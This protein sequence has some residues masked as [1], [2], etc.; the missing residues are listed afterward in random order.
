MSQTRQ[1]SQTLATQLNRPVPANSDRP[2]SSVDK[3]R[4]HS[5]QFTAPAEEDDVVPAVNDNGYASVNL[6]ISDQYPNTN[7]R[8][9]NTRKGRSG[10]PA[11]TPPPS[12]PIKRRPKKQDAS[13]SVPPLGRFI[14][15]PEQGLKPLNALPGE[16]FQRFST[17]LDNLFT[18]KKYVDRACKKLS[19]DNQTEVIESGQCIA[20]HIIWKTKTEPTTK[21]DLACKTCCD[22]AEPRPCVKLVRDEA[23]VPV[24][25]FFPRPADRRPSG[26]TW[27]SAQY[28]LGIQGRI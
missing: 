8:E 9:S 16:L 12:L 5:H 11:V 7:S 28:W 1:I 25:V 22:A 3:K 4:K 26:V 27:T 13:K 10:A 23:D 20:R 6:P 19:H 24:L 14:F 21:T 17:W 18:D 2:Y 15:V